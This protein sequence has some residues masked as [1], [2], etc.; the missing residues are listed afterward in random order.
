MNI[1]HYLVM[2]LVMGALQLA[3]CAGY[4]PNKRQNLRSE[5]L[6]IEQSIARFVERDPGMQV[7]FDHAYGYALFPKVGKG[8]VGVGGAHGDGR[9]YEQG[10][11]IGNTSMTQVT[12]GFQLGGQAF[13]EVVFFEDEYALDNFKNDEYSFNAQVSAVAATKGAS[14]DADYEQGVAV[15]SMTLGGLMYE[16]SVG[17]QRFK[18]Y[19]L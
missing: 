17:G 1:K 4:D 13:S 11:Y 5:D 6:A 9:V 15:F 2:S 19:P 14:R 12:I 10:R 7:F 8:A 18:F 3:G 16:A